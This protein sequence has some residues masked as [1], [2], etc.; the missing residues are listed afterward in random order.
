MLTSVP[1][2]G[3][4]AHIGVQSPF[5]LILSTEP[6]Q[7]VGN[8][9][10][11]TIPGHRFNLTVVFIK[12]ILKIIDAADRLIQRVLYHFNVGFAALQQVDDLLELILDLMRP[13]FREGW[14]RSINT[15]TAKP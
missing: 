1:C 10:S 12:F 6:L 8:G 11:N 9:V 14:M 3:P 5:A 2:G 15:P 13:P 4:N 7:N